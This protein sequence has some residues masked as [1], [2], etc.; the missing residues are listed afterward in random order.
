MKNTVIRQVIN[1]AFAAAGDAVK[2]VVLIR[3]TK[4]EYE[5]GTRV[6]ETITEYVARFLWADK[7]LAARSAVETSLI[8]PLSR[9]GLLA[10]ADAVPRID[11]DMQISGETF[12]LLQVLPADMGA[13]VLYEVMIR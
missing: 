3:K 11:D 10:C 9:Y 7:L 8:E 12:T 13:G 2:E 1:R 4:G 6:P 5:P